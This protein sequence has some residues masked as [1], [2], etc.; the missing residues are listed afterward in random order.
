MTTAQTA[1]PATEAT[2][3]S[4]TAPGTGLAAV[5]TQPPASET[6]RRL[7]RYQLAS[8][9][10]VLLLGVVGVAQIGQLRAE[11]AA[12]PAVGA[13]HVRIGE[14]SGSISAA[15]N[16]AAADL[17]AGSDSG[18]SVR[19]LGDAAN[20]LVAAAAAEPARADAVGTINTELVRY[21]QLVATGQFDQAATLFNESLQPGLDA[22]SQSLSDAA[23]K[24]TWWTSGWLSFGVGL[25]V[26]VGLCWMSYQVAQRS[27]RVLNA[28]LAAAI[29]TTV[30][31]T[32]LAAAATPV[33][34]GATGADSA[35]VQSSSQLTSAQLQSDA[36]TR[37]LLDAIRNKRWDKAAKDAFAA[38]DKQADGS[39]SAG[40]GQQYSSVQA[41]RKTVTVALTA[42]DWAK[43]ATLVSG[44]GDLAGAEEALAAEITDQRASLGTSTTSDSSRGSLLFFFEIGAA[45]I[46]LAGAFL[47]VRG[48]QTRIEEYR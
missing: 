29:V 37:A 10:A 11:M 40:L 5:I 32:G 15:G 42:G 33:S 43:A 4:T 6:P 12:A 18:R 47:S 26:L 28:G 38:A 46:A 25:V 21:G 27:H 30:A 13:Q 8:A 19:S 2:A 41:A 31:I 20:G 39:L 48:L 34:G 45:I 36:A 23:A 44:D 1:R 35:L 22:L 3:T 16:Q 24:T 7:R 9:V 17:L 14:I